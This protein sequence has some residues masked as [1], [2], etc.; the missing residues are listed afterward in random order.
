MLTICYRSPPVGG[1]KPELRMMAAEYPSTWEGCKEI[2]KH[3][4]EQL[5][6]DMETYLLPILVLM[7]GGKVCPT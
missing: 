3:L 4:M 1:M 7:K 6:N 5:H 2:E